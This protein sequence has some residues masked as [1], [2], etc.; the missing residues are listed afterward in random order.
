MLPKLSKIPYERLALIHNYFMESKEQLSVVE[1]CTGGLLSFYLTSLPGASVYFK[2]GIISYQ[3]EIKKLELGFSDQIMKTQGLANAKAAQ[4]MA[5]SVKLKW[6][7]D[8][9]I[10]TTG[11]AGPALGELGENVGK[12]AFSVCSPHT[13]KSIEKQFYDKHRQNFRYKATLFALDFLISEF[14]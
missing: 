13:E 1:S 4:N 9:V 10:S 3:K 14:K 12:I 7:S 11:I 6:S 8:W 2:G 5:Q